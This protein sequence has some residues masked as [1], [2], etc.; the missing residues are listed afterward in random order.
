[1]KKLREKKV[2]QTLKVRSRPQ[3]NADRYCPKMNVRARRR[4]D[5]LCGDEPEGRR[6]LSQKQSKFGKSLSGFLDIVLVLW[7][8]GQRV[9]LRGM[10]TDRL[11][12]DTRAVPRALPGRHLPACTGQSKGLFEP[13]V[14]EQQVESCSQC[15]GRNKHVSGSQLRLG[16]QGI[17]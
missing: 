7:L 10:R 8:G 4:W 13:L 6:I 2:T 14:P 15:S 11:G 1:M 17:H 9:E 12:G 5:F 3:S 16:A